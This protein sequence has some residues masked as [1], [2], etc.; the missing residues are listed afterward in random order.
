M[1]RRFRKMWIKKRHKF[2]KKKLF[3]SSQ[4]FSVYLLAQIN[5]KEWTFPLRIC[6]VNV[7]ILNKTEDL[8]TFIKETLNAKLAS[9]YLNL[10][11]S[12]SHI[13]HKSTLETD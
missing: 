1:Q 5:A 7:K 6:L 10:V 12:L 8:L 13:L 11:A 2:S 3:S 9:F 4:Q